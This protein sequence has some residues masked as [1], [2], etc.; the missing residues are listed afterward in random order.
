M[1]NLGPHILP[2]G[3]EITLEHH[4][5]GLNLRDCPFARTCWVLFLCFPLDFQSRNYIEQAVNIFGTVL[6][7]TNNDNYKS[8][9]LVRCSV[10]HVSKIPRSVIVCKP[11]LV[12]GAGQ[13]WLVPVF[14][15]N[16]QNNDQLPADEDPIPQD[17]NPHPLPEQQQNL[18]HDFWEN[19]QD[20][21]DVE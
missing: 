18:Q 17:G 3:R 11:R 13:S 21:Q 7:W 14:V 4:D 1:I 16:S 19:V 10:L 12:G 20:L 9:V 8:R 5:R 15:L 6:T 2:K